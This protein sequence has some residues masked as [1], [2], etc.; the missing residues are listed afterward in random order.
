MLVRPCH[1]AYVKTFVNAR[2]RDH[3]VRNPHAVH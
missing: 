2:I 1:Q 3:P